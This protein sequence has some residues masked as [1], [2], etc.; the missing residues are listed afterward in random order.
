MSDDGELIVGSAPRLLFDDSLKPRRS[1]IL[2]VLALTVVWGAVIFLAA[3]ND[4][5]LRLPGIGRGLLEHYGFMACFLTG[6]FVLL[7]TY[8]AVAYFLGLVRD[9]DQFLVDGADREAAGEIVK[10]HVES[11]FLRGRW[12]YMLFLFAFIGVAVSLADFAPLDHPEAYWGNDVFNA[13]Y[14]VAS[15]ATANSYLLLL[16]SAIYPIGL[17]YVFHLAI[18]SQLIVINLMRRKMLR[19]NFLHIDRCAG[20]AKFGTLNLLLMLIYF[21]MAL[22]AFALHITHRSAYASL[23]I[24][25]IAV[26]ALFVA[27]S[28]FGIAWVAKAIR[29]QRDEAVVSLNERIRNMMEGNKS[30]FTAAVATMA[31]RDRVLAVATFPYSGGISYAVNFLRVA[32]AAVVIA[33]LVAPGLAPP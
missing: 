1:V 21:W 31:Y 4:H 18:S 11:V 15:W 29:T 32:P 9:I 5:V 8:A 24:G 20:M 10:P 16:W 13:R 26:T 6:P 17:F 25:G 2:G 7:N 19:L 3:A 33:K 12:K 22:A 14:Y 27:H 28:I 30:K 23:V